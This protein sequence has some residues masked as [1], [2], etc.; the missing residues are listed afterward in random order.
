MKK[1]NSVARIVIHISTKNP[2][3]LLSAAHLIV[4]LMFSVP[5]LWSSTLGTEPLPQ[6]SSVFSAVLSFINCKHS[7]KLFYYCLTRK[8]IRSHKS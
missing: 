3:L 6:L 8:L 5:H 4:T 1:V 7:I 2:S